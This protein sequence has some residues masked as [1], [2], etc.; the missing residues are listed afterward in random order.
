MHRAVDYI[1]DDEDAF[2]TFLSDGRIDMHNIARERYFS[3]IAM[4]RR[5]WLLT[6]NVTMFAIL[7]M[8]RMRS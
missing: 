6:G 1:L 5:N 8:V 4:G 2:R 7:K 3:H